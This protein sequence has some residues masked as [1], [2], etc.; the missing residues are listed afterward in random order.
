MVVSGVSTTGDLEFSKVVRRALSFD[1]R[2][3]DE[4]EDGGVVEASVNCLRT[5]NFAASSDDETEVPIGEAGV[6]VVVGLFVEE[7]VFNLLI[8]SDTLGEAC[9]A[10]CARRAFNL[11]AKACP[12]DKVG[13]GGV[14][15]LCTL[16]FLVIS[17]TDGVRVGEEDADDCEEAEFSKALR[18]AIFSSNSE[19]FFSRGGG[20]AI[21]VDWEMFVVVLCVCLCIQIDTMGTW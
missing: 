10:S 15:G 4:V 8:K 2:S 6:V 7:D 21:I 18:R 11:K 19:S 14:A 17:A 1:S 20:V 16:N 13:T 9:S 12:G 5:F 3:D